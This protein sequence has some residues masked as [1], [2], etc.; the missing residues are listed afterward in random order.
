MESGTGQGKPA[1]EAVPDTENLQMGR[2]HSFTRR[3]RGQR[4]QIVDEEAKK[5]R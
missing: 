3:N 2:G 1:D 4:T 5:N